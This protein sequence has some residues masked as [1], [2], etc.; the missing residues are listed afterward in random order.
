MATRRDAREWAV[1]MLFRLEMNPCDNEKLFDEFFEERDADKKARAFAENLIKGVRDNREEIDKLIVQYAKN[2]TIDRMAIIDRNVIRV[3]LYELLYC[4]DIPPAVVIN[5]A[6]DIA[7]YFNKSE[8][9]R[10][11]NGILDSAKKEIL[12]M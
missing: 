1:Q 9:G 6:V 7:K 4:K 5:E 2:W 3:A 8:S 11:V 10:F 12:K